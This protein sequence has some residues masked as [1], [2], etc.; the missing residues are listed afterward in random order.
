LAATHLDGFY[1]ATHHEA[2]GQDGFGVGCDSG[3][4]GLWYQNWVETNKTQPTC[5]PTLEG[6]GP[7]RDDS[8]VHWTPSIMDRL[9]QQGVPWKIYGAG[10]PGDGVGYGWSICPTFANCL[11][12]PEMHQHFI[13]R[14]N[15][16]VDAANGDLPAF[17]FLIPDNEPSQHNSRSMLLGDNWI[18]D[19]ATAVMNG[20]DWNSTALFITYD[21]AGIFY[22]HVPPPASMT[23]AY[24]TGIRMPMVIVSPWAKPAYTDSNNATWASVL[25]FVEKN[26]GLAPLSDIDYKSYDYM[27]AFDFTQQPI[28]PI[29]I[30]P[31]PI[32]AHVIRWMQEHP[33]DPNDPT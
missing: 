33:D 24:Y 3:N 11:I 27:E 19:V 12:N 25:A 6:E 22:D 21:D 5:V 30:N 7:F 15:F 13:D 18:G 14:S 20:P 28:A 32:P 16:F 29:T 9:A 17:S 26:Y 23:G 8:K 10:H 1:T 4:V 2:E 31:T